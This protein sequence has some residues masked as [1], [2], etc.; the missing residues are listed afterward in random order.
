MQ[1]QHKCV[2]YHSGILSVI[3]CIFLEG[4]YSERQLAT[5]V[6]SRTIVEEISTA[7]A[8]HFLLSIGPGGRECGRLSAKTCMPR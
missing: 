4:C 8:M 7:Q 1:S 3:D 6:A 5:Y 2:Y